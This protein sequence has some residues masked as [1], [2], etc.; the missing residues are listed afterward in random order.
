MS[1][2]ILFRNA[3]NS[4]E[5]N[6]AGTYDES[7]VK[8]DLQNRSKLTLNDQSSLTGN[9][10][11]QFNTQI[12]GLKDNGK[13]YYYQIGLVNNTE[14]SLT[15]SRWTGDL[16]DEINLNGT[17]LGEAVNKEDA[18]SKNV[19]SL[20]NGS[21]WTGGVDVAKKSTVDVTL[22]ETSSWTVSSNSR[23]NSIGLAPSESR[24]AAKNSG[25]TIGNGVTLTIAEGS[26][27]STISSLQTGTGSSLEVESAQVTINSIGG[28]GT[29]QLNKNGVVTIEAASDDV[30]ATLTSLEGS[31]L[32]TAEDV[33]ASVTIAGALADEMG[34][35]AVIKAYN[36]RK[37]YAGNGKVTFSGGLIGDDLI[38]RNDENGVFVQESSRKNTQLVSIGEGTAITM[39]QWRADADDMAQRMGDLRSGD[40]TA[41]AWVRTF[42]G[43]AEAGHVD[44]K[45]YGIQAGVDALIG[46][47][48]TKQFAGGALSYATGDADFANGTGENYIG[49]LTGY[50]TWLFENGA[51]IDLTAKWGKLH[52]EFDLAVDTRK[53]SGR[54][55]TQALALTVESGHRFPL[56]RLTY[57]EPQVAFTASHIFG[58]D[59][60]ASEGVTVEQDSINSYVARVGLQA[61]VNCPNNMGVFFVRASY[62]Y[63]LDGETSTT[64]RM[65]NAKDANR[66]DQDFG[67][68][69]YEFGLG[70]N[71][72]FTKNLYGYADFE[73]VTGG[74]IKTPYRWN[75]GVR[76]AF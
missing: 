44:N 12:E 7:M 22:D 68:G 62:L 42:G 18:L 24:Q 15:S 26:S 51:Y 34:M 50:S 5:T 13:Y 56:S 11:N 37:N 45:Y 40:G 29:V 19:I 9:V 70:M 30:N 67:G 72:N 76:Y 16:K 59:Y 14:V 3:S 53:L 17:S 23:V 36:D 54:Y 43:K 47:G 39:M 66:F 20:K 75:A 1:R 35:D 28:S 61:G 2:G 33:S 74:E 4:I 41:G 38:G 58:E 63:D 31:K 49:T 60:G 21:I 65:A 52:N 55:N 27:A 32:T 10:I 71:V 6:Q 73:Y 69:W 57:V 46:S 25:V 8:K 64:A 48:G